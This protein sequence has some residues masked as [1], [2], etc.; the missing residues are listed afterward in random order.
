M[1]LDFYNCCKLSYRHIVSGGARNLMLG[2]LNYIFCQDK[3][4]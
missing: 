2:E 1:V 4:N 3:L